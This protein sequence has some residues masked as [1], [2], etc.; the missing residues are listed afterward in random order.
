MPKCKV[1]Y[2]SK[3]FFHIERIAEHHLKMVGVESAERITNKLLEGFLI[4]EDY[5]LAGAAHPDLVLQ[6]QGYR[7][8]IVGEYVGVYRKVGE[9]IYIY[10]VFHGSTDYPKLFI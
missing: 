3:A 6:R 4:L 5:P 2:T 8:L 1:E 10:G 9:V 7:K